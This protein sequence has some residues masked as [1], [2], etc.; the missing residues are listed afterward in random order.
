MYKGQSKL[1]NPLCKRK[2]TLEVIT[3]SYVTS[4]ILMKYYI[5]WTRHEYGYGNLT[6]EIC[7]NLQNTEENQ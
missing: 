1:F 3:S 4:T 7:E 5:Q 2:S 6:L